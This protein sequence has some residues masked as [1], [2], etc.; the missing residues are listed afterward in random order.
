MRIDYSGIP[1]DLADLA[2]DWWTQFDHWLAEAVAASVTEPNAM[3]LATASTDGEPSS[4][5]VLAKHIG[6]DG[7]IFYTNYASTKSADLVANPRASATF[8]WLPLH[9][10]VH[11][12]GAVER[13]DAGTTA[14]YWRTRPRGSQIGAW[15][16]TVVPQSSVVPDRATLDAA[17][18]QLEQRFGGP[19][20]TE[21]IPV[22]PQWGGWRIVP[23]TVEFWQGRSGRLHDRLRFRQETS[24]EWSVQRLA[25]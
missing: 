23:H 15:A 25:P 19:D 16:S 4:R 6:E 22:P 21:E 7:V 14:T 13:V 1:F 12:R 8:C 20:G 3:V 10:Q 5:N 2:G 18:Q 17:Q 11:L 24:A 9:R